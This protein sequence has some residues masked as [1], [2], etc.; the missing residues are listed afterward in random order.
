M[1]PASKLAAA[2]SVVDCFLFVP[3]TVSPH[4]IKVVFAR[5]SSKPGCMATAGSDGEEEV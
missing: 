3:G 5:V 4:I 1:Y 2:G